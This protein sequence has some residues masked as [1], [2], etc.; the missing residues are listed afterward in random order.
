M[1]PKKVLIVGGG[2]A[3]WT[4]A[5]YLNAVLDENGRRPVEIGVVESPEIQGVG[6]A[7]A[8]TPNIRHILAVIGI[9]EID[10]LKSVNGTFKQA[11]KFV[12]WLRGTGDF[13]YHA[14]DN[15]RAQPIDRAAIEWLMS[16]RSIAFAETVS[17]QPVIC[18]LGLAPRPLGGQSAAVPLEYAY[19]MD[20]LKFA[21]MLREVATS[22]GVKHHRDYVTEVDMADNG[23]IA[24][25]LTK[26]GQRL[27]ADLFI[28]CTGSAAL[29]ID[30]QLGVK[31]VDCSQWLLCDREVVMNVD[32]EDHY[33]GYVRPYTTATA[34][35]AGWVREIPLQ[36]RKT[37]GY[38]HCSRYIDEEDARHEMRAF[39][40]RHAQS[41]ET[42]TVNL[43]VGHRAKSWARNCVSLGHS[44]GFIEPL[45]SASLYLSDLGTVTLAEH[46]PFDDDMAP[47]A[48]RYNR[49]MA[50][51]Y[52]EILDF[53]NMHYCLTKRADTEFWREVAKPERIN[54]RLKAKLD[55]WKLKVPSK[56]DFVDQRLPGQP[57]MPLPSGGLPGDHRSPVDTA[58]V[59]GL[60]SYE[61]IL[62]GMQFL[63]DECNDW[64]GTRRPP[65]RVPNYII[66]DL[67]RAP[68]TLPPHEVWLKNAIGMPD[69]RVSPGARR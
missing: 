9:D 39:E 1:I 5:A 30:K 41:L 61:S 7:E 14:F 45:E 21:D 57:E 8:A 34:L 31:W 18:D 22:R 44:G 69:Y 55:F 12:N 48:F 29:L 43:K 63:A 20:A 27:E 33:S 36:N 38:V 2:R 65:T 32:Y 16:D 23:D 3:G 52:Y 66:D 15:S 56:S 59:F 50:N 64:F 40:G 54:D 47:F 19:H 53:I 11:T 46:F 17:P 4:A 67:K 51:R 58:A 35:S 60:E 26:A 49:I 37:L 13:Y 68:G 28:D 62:Y 25:V 24:A 10:F 42:H 6:A